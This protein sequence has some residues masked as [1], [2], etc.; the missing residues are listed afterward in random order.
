[1]ARQSL[2]KV[3][4]E[5]RE[6]GLAYPETTEDFPWGHRTLKVKGKAFIFMATEEG[7]F[8][9]SVKLPFAAPAA[10]SLPNVEPTG[11]GMGKSNW[12]T[13]RWTKGDDV[14]VAL[15]RS[16]MDESYRAVAPKRVVAQLDGG[17][18]AAV[19]KAKP[20]AKKAAPRKRARSS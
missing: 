3:E 9:L 7:E 16:W 1:M 5:L 10:L 4:M 20:A 6:F 19:K 2:E 8:S 11:Y 15:I 13:A 12:V 14:D 17:K 18:T